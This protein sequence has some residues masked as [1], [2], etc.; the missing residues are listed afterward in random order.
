MINDNNKGSDNNNKTKR[1]FTLEQA[2]SLEIPSETN[3]TFF[4]ANCANLDEKFILNNAT[5]CCDFKKGRISNCT[6]KDSYLNSC[7][8]EDMIFENCR[9][10]NV[11]F[12]KSEYVNCTFQNCAILDDSNLTKVQ[13][14]NTIIKNCSLKGIILNSADFVKCS[15]I[16]TIFDNCSLC[17]TLI[18]E[19]KIKNLTTSNLF[20]SEKTPL[21]VTKS[22]DGPWTELTDLVGF[23]EFI[24]A[25]DLE[26]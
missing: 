13:F 11:N 4:N 9:F 25:Q 15:I 2:V 19:T 23:E 3:Y 6:F 10:I 18:S 16:N 20:F 17:S 22:K 26:P 8:F 12:R 24:K 1:D 14:E 5:C 21:F 7:I